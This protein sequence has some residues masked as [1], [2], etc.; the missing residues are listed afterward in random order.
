MSCVRARMCLVVPW[1]ETGF[2]SFS[3]LKTFFSVLPRQFIQAVMSSICFTSLVGFLNHFTCYFLCYMLHILKWLVFNQISTQK[4]R[5]MLAAV[6]QGQSQYLVL[7]GCW[8]DS[9]GLH[10]EVS[11]DKILNPKLVGTL[12]GSHHHQCMN[13]CK[14][15]WT[16]ASGTCP[17]KWW[18]RK[19]INECKAKW[20]KF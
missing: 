6:A 5:S 17:K 19:Q 2:V 12:H 4:N 11:L 3:N 10:V 1:G 9:P 14:S 15:L 7:K 13:D 8:F 18:H 16:E 20:L